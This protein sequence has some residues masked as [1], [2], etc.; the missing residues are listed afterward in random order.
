MPTPSQWRLTDFA[1]QF[2]PRGPRCRAEQNGPIP[3]LPKSKSPKS[4]V[5][6]PRSPYRRFHAPDPAHRARA[7]ARRHCHDI[8]C[9][10]GQGSNFE[11]SRPIFELF[12]P[13]FRLFRTGNDY[14]MKN[15]KA[16]TIG[17]AWQRHGPRRGSSTRVPCKS[18]FSI[19]PP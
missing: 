18:V 11:S 2:Q 8:K 17:R 4:Q 16:M 3:L 9:I 14:G 6:S 1:K 5:S 10:P 15:A 12:S 19:M 13:V 7:S